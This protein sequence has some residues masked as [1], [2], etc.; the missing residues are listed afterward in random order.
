MDT[1]VSADG[2]IFKVREIAKQYQMSPSQVY[3]LI[4]KEGLPAIRLGKRGIRVREKDL[5]TWMESRTFPR[6]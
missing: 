3:T 5:L 4:R 1:P 2:R 6:P